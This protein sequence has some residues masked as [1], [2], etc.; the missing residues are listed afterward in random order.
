MSV[1]VRT[2]F[3]IFK[4]DKFT[5]QYCGQ[6][7][8]LVVLEIDHILPI[9]EGGGDDILNLITSCWGCNRGKGGIPLDHVVIGEDPYDRS[10][11]LLERERQLRE[12]N[13]VLEEINTRVD[14]DLERLRELWPRNIYGREETGL[15]NALER[16]PRETI[17][18]AM[19]R[20]VRNHKTSGFAYVHACLNNGEQA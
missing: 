6:S 2:R 3:D 15:R 13:A 17:A 9:C 19:R 4:R 14:Q 5:C 10:V 8:P 1:S 7:S 11:A 20:A 16:H 12:Y 18:E